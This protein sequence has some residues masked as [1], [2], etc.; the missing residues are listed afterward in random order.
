[1]RPV[2]RRTGW[3]FPLRV[4]L[5]FLVVGTLLPTL[6]L[7]G[8]L[9]LR[10]IRDGRET[11]R[12][13]LLEAARAQ[14]TIVD[15]ELLGTIR[16][17]R[18]L[19]ESKALRAGDLDGF[20]DEALRVEQT[21]PSWY[22]VVLHTAKGAAIV[23]VAKSF[24]AVVPSV[25]EGDSLPQILATGQPLIG[26]LRG[27]S[28]FGEQL[29]FPVHVP[30]MQD[31]RLVYILS[32]VIT[33]DRLANLLRGQSTLSDEWVRGVMDNNAVLVARTRDSARFVGEKGTPDTKNVT[34][35]NFVDVGWRHDPRTGRVVLLS[36]EDNLVKGAA[37]QA[38]QSL[39]V[40][41]GWPETTAL[42]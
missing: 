13:Q 15:S 7:T 28:D 1:M 39:N 17:L 18:A 35:T 22:D 12:R 36:A 10:V 25:I 31:G 4:H 3:S 21:Q 5:L 9:M 24:G 37:G 32:A 34:F 30:V 40:M 11:V 29:A 23:N 14:A 26:N 6:A 38:V 42:L 27:G 20:R 19:A 8:V 2:S 16:A 41:C 33:P